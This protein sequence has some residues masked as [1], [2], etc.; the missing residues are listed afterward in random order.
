MSFHQQRQRWTIHKT[1]SRWMPECPAQMF[2]VS[3]H[4]HNTHLFLF[5]YRFIFASSIEIIIMWF[6]N[7]FY[8]ILIRTKRAN[9]KKRIGKKATEWC[10]LISIYVNVKSRRSKIERRRCLWMYVWNTNVSQ[11]MDEVSEC[12]LFVYM[13]W[14]E[15][16]KGTSPAA[17]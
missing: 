9:K 11:T 3:F 17:W 10:C 12:K 5:I 13:K 16:K 8:K 2:S 4:T 14:I 15:I 7:L 1:R 6:F